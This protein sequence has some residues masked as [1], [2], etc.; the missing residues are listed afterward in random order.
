M[1]DYA[2]VPGGSLKLK[3]GSNDKKKKK[4]S[5]SASERT[6]VDS[7]IKLQEKE[8]NHKSREQVLSED[9]PSGSGSPAPTR[10]EDEPKMTDAERRFLEAQKKRREERVKHTAKMTHK[11]RVSEFN[12]KLDRLSEHHDMPRIGPG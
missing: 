10:K 7:E 1:S 5:H 8:R 9:V 12:A 3:G 2:F 6:K 11:E 4:K